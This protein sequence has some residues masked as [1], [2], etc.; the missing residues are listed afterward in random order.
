MKKY[1]VGDEVC[2]EECWEDI[3]GHYHDETATIKKIF[4][5]GS[6]KLQWHVK[7]WKIKAFLNSFSFTLEDIV[8]L[9]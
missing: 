5:D 7:S 4:D 3:A 9:A 6:L 8:S 1:K 2:F